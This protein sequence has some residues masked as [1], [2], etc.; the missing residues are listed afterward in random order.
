MNANTE[1]KE[2]T[3][4]TELNDAEIMMLGCMLESTEK[5]H[6][7]V[8]FCNE[9]FGV[10]NERSEVARL[11]LEDY[12]K[13]NYKVVESHN[14]NYQTYKWIDLNPWADL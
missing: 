2:Y 6:N 3:Y 12:I 13:E 5:H 4:K 10:F 1:Y 8:S 11:Q 7:A 9:V 14:G